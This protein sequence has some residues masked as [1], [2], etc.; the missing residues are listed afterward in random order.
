V[1][2]KLMLL[3]T[4]LAIFFA[5]LG[6]FASSATISVRDLLKRPDSY[7]G[8]TVTVSGFVDLGA[9]PD[10]VRNRAIYQSASA[11]HAAERRYQAGKPPVDGL[12]LTIANPDRLDAER[13]KFHHRTVRLTGRLIAAEVMNSCSTPFAFQLD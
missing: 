12:C 10:I 9:P 13:R 11:L 4:P 1:K 2:T 7:V 3:V 8:R 5:P 6:V